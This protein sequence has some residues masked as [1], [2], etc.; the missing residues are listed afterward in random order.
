LGEGLRKGEGGI[1][2]WGGV[3]LEERKVSSGGWGK[4]ELSDRRKRKGIV[5]KRNKNN[6]VI[7][8]WGGEKLPWKKT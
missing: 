6:Q 1:Y 5:R 3:Y 2:L 4:G 7:R 8:N